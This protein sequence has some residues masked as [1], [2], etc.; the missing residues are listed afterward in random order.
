M[1]LEIQLTVVNFYFFLTYIL[2]YKAFIT[3]FWIIKSFLN[4]LLEWPNN[5]WKTNNIL[6]WLGQ[7]GWHL[8]TASYI[9][10]FTLFCN[11][12]LCMWLHANL[13]FSIV[14]VRSETVHFLKSISSIAIY[15]CS[16]YYW[17]TTYRLQNR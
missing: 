13:Y 15:L 1:L 2:G 14:I 5:I 10:N 8:I 6:R 9:I 12:N 11:A 4:Y 17:H 7:L 16:T 3:L